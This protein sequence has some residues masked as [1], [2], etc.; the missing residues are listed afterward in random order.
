MEPI[1]PEDF[2]EVEL[3]IPQYSPDELYDRILTWQRILFMIKN[4]R[5]HTIV[6]NPITPEREITNKVIYIDIFE[7]ENSTK[8]KIRVTMIQSRKLIVLADEVSIIGSTYE[9]IEHLL[10]HIG[11]EMDTKLV[12][13]F[14]SKKYIERRIN[15]I[16]IKYGLLAFTP[17]IPLLLFVN[18]GL[19]EGQGW[20]LVIGFTPLYLIVI[21]LLYAYSKHRKW[22]KRLEIV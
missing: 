9:V 5:P 13:Q 6:V 4:E 3:D 2:V 20:D 15:A 1:Y 10:Q 11:I 7:K 16:W 18:D 8:M 17:V 19:L 22:K 12:T 21:V 14:Y